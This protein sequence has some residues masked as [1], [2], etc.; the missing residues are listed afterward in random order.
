MYFCIKVLTIFL[1]SFQLRASDSEDVWS[2]LVSF[3]CKPEKR[4]HNNKK[5]SLYWWFFLC[6]FSNGSTYCV[7]EFHRLNWFDFFPLCI[8]KC[9]LKLPARADA[10]LHWLHLFD[11]SPLCV[12]KCRSKSPACEDVKSHWLHLLA[13]SPLCII[14]CLPKLPA[15]EDA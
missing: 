1:F 8:F 4:H 12:F 7:Q 9:L 6:M 11:L 3:V 15:C 10:K 5:K 13:F 2:L 14:K